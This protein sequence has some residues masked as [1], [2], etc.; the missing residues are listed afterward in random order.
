MDTTKEQDKVI[1]DFHI[2]RKTISNL[3]EGLLSS[4][5]AEYYRQFEPILPGMKAEL[6]ILHD[7]LR[8]IYNDVSSYKIKKFDTVDKI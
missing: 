4:G 5:L 8:D 1:N 6:Q 2:L 7:K 3:E